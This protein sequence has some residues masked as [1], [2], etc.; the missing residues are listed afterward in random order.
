MTLDELKDHF[1][2]KKANGVTLTW[3]QFAMA[4]STAG[5]MVRNA[6]LQAVNTGKPSQAATL[7]V[8]LVRDKKLEIAMADVET[9]LAD[10]TIT[11]SE[12]LDMMS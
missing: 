10:G 9:K 8:N 6:I 3:A 12:L 7:L 2:T 1:A 4:V 5:P 11:V